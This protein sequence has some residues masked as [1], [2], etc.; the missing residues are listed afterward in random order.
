MTVG[1]E[2]GVSAGAVRPGVGVQVFSGITVG[3]DGTAEIVGS[4]K[5]FPGR[6][7]GPW[8]PQ[9]AVRISTS[10]RT[11]VLS[12]LF[13]FLRSF[14]CTGPFLIIWFYHILSFGERALFHSVL[15]G[16]PGFLLP[17]LSLLIETLS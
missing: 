16:F 4:E 7:V 1:V 2:A 14:T 11:G 10:K 8:L 15:M 3:V 9:P 5:V 17:V 13:F 12:G 6:D